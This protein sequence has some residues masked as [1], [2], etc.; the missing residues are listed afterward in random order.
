MEALPVTVRQLRV[1]TSTDKILSKVIRF[2][3]R[4]WPHGVQAN[5][6]PFFCRRNE[7]LVEEGCLLWE[8]RVVIPHRQRTKLLQELHQ[9]HPGVTQMKSVA[10]SCM[11]WPGP[12]KE[13]ENLAKLCSACQAAKQAPPVA[14]LH[15]WVWPSKC[16]QQVHLDSVGVDSKE[17]CF[18][19]QLM[20]SQN[21]QRYE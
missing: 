11:W 6:R 14:P 16:W 18:D 3:N 10:R 13:I 9:D 5:L 1:A 7:L 20:P 17:P 15:L 19:L 21:G 4:S 2:T 12:D 8:F